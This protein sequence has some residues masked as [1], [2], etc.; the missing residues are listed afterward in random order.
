MPKLHTRAVEIAVEIYLVCCFIKSF[1]VFPYAVS[2]LAG[3]PSIGFNEYLSEARI[4]PV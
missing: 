3:P 4:A 1:F 2:A